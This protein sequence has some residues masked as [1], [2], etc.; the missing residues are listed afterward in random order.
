[1]YPYNSFVTQENPP[2]FLGSAACL[3]IYL[4]FF[5]TQENPPDFLDSSMEFAPQIPSMSAV[6][7]WLSLRQRAQAAL[8]S[9]RC[10]KNGHQIVILLSVFFYNYFA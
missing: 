1:M 7:K 2:D 4:L 6:A 8:G 10:T 5:V 3:F 9:P